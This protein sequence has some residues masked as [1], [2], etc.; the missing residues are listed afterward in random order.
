MNS[1]NWA[2][3]WHRAA[4]VGERLWSGQPLPPLTDVTRVR[5]YN[6]L[7]E[8]NCYLARR[9]RHTDWFFL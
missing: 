7:I 3:A 5:F 8:F 4:A 6:R 9:G 1:N 2:I